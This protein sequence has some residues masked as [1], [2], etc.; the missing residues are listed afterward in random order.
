MVNVQRDSSIV[1]VMV[2]LLISLVV[3]EA[4]QAAQDRTRNDLGVLGGLGSR[5]IE[6]HDRALTFGAAYASGSPAY[7]FLG[8]GPSYEPYE[9]LFGRPNRMGFVR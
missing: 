1:R 3:V 4:A 9:I 8:D 6:M 7:T 2:L 5:T